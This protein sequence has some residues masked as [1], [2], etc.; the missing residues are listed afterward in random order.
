MNEDLAAEDKVLADALRKRQERLT[1][2]MKIQA[3]T[4]GSRRR[5]WTDVGDESDQDENCNY[6]ELNFD[7]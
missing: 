3:A 4:E 7:R 2:M 1:S 6:K 5:R